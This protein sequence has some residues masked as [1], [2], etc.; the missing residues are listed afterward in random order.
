MAE[1]FDPYT[2]WLE[3]A[4]QR[5]PPS[6]YSILGVKQGESRGAVIEQQA[7]RQKQKLA[8]HLEGPDA[9]L[10]KRLAF[11]I[12]A[13]RSCLTDPGKRAAYNQ[14]LSPAR[15][16]GGQAS[17]VRSGRARQAK[18]ASPSPARPATPGPRPGTAGA[19]A[20]ES[21]VAPAPAGSPAE[22]QTA[23]TAEQVVKFPAPSPMLFVAAGV[24]ALLL[25][26]ALIW[27]VAAGTSGSRHDARP[28]SE[29]AGRDP[30]ELAA[31]PAPPA[32]PSMGS[33]GLG[34]PVEREHASVTHCDDAPASSPRAPGDEQER[35]QPG[36]PIA[37]SRQS[38]HS[39][40]L[41]DAVSPMDPDDQG[42]ELREEPAPS[43]ELARPAVDKLAPDDS[44][45]ET[46]A[47]PLT[48]KPVPEFAEQQVVRDLIDE[49]FDT[50]SARTSG[51]RRR[52]ADTLASLAEETDDATE[53]FTLLR[54]AAELASDAGDARVML[55]LVDRIAEEFAFDRLSAR[56]VMLN[57]CAQN[58]SE[59]RQIKALVAA[60]AVVV[61]EALAADRVDL[62]YS[63]SASVYQACLPPAPADAAVRKAALGRRRELEALHERWEEVQAAR[64]TLRANPA[65]EAANTIVG[66]WYCFLRDDWDRAL[67]HLAKGSDPQLRA[68]AE[69][70]LNSPPDEAMAQVDLADGWWDLAEAGE[71]AIKDR[72][73][74]RAAHWYHLALPKLTG[75]HRER[76]AKRLQELPGGSEPDEQLPLEEGRLR[77]GFAGRSGPNRARL[78][79]EAGGSEASEAAVAR[80][81][82]WF[83]RHQ[84][85]DGGWSF[86]HTVHPRC[87]GKC[88]NPGR[89]PQARNAAT[90]LALLPFL[91]AGQTHQEGKYRQTIQS[92]LH[93][94][95]NNMK[96]SNRGGSFWEDGGRLYSHG[97]A[98]IALV[99][100][101]GM[102]QDPT[103]L[104]PAQAVVNY[105]CYAQDPVGGGWRYQPRQKGDTSVLAWQL[106]ALKS[107]EMS[108]L[109]VP[110]EVVRKASLFL[111]SVQA[112]GGATYG[113]TGPGSGRAT[114]AIG[115]L[116][117]M[118]L[119][120]DKEQ[121]ALRRGVHSLSNWG[122][123]TSGDM[124]YN[125]Y[126]T[127]VAR[128][129]EGD[130]WK[131]WNSRM[132][133]WLV[134]SQE[135]AG[136]EA[137]SWHFRGGDHGA[138]RGGRLYC[139]SLATLVLQAYYRHTPLYENG[140]W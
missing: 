60:S 63:L 72:S 56:A 13:A 23:G 28:P 31:P 111:D 135:K 112:G 79:A 49:E 3:V 34:D 128:H 115:L 108:D 20:G 58:A 124:Y 101:Y 71:D 26:G 59:E 134:E 52:L 36:K 116:S 24:A 21:V 7:R 8:P 78:V 104:R 87:R 103:L 83:A 29:L 4:N 123:S 122:V 50:A 53:R 12:E 139:T 41:D 77:G 16:R 94:L 1:S 51:E 25:F 27:W 5:R 37:E 61:D 45:T 138:E 10:A 18:A 140:E 65:H 33:S 64:K 6:H 118:Y 131:K 39:S 93:Y 44:K 98:A 55:E 127:Q 126:A 47:A 85:P 69:R 75:L 110:P 32:E 99:E 129:W 81:L 84:L 43:V 22:G 86:E 132:Q 120:W 40:P 82:E 97:M 46:T 15:G 137:G 100:A 114:T 2:E 133:N 95:V 68:L 106:A 62:A 90:A 130:V 38:V 76:V 70:E 9:R 11:E 42:D 102:T 35:A 17:A 57:T 125:Y 66:Q 30:S 92:G 107:A 119:G 67:P 48:P 89:L 88:G 74:G 14:T 121:A 113:Y 80:A 91:S 109:R 105:I 54:R 117:R 136:C 19:V 73:Q 96:V